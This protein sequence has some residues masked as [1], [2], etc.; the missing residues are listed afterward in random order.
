MTVYPRQ[1]LGK[2]RVRNMTKTATWNDRINK[3]AQIIQSPFTKSKERKSFKYTV[4][5]ST[6]GKNYLTEY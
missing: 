5:D 4:Q 6:S 1:C 2:D 3:N